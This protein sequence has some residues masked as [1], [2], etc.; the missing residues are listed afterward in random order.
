M[1]KTPVP[2][3]PKLSDGLELKFKEKTRDKFHELLKEALKRQH[4]LVPIKVQ[5]TTI[6]VTATA[7]L[8]GVA[9]IKR[10]IERQTKE[11]QDEIKSAFQDL[12]S[13]KEKA[14]NMVAIANSI[15][16]KIQKK[17]VNT[18]S[19]EMKEIQ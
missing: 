15:K 18:E 7:A 13:L 2:S 3:P 1:A 16:A 12:D 5:Q 9:D 8:G 10:Q 14:R 17:E 6:K 11:S 19:E 4:W